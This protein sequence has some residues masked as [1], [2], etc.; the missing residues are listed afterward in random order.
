MHT[1][2][3]LCLVTPEAWAAE[4]VFAG[5]VEKAQEL[6]EH[7]GRWTQDRGSCPSS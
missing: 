6:R 7:E 1:V 5:V 4:C 2:P 3:V